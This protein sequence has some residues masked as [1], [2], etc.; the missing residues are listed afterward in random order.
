MDHEHDHEE[1]EDLSERSF[2]V[3]WW[4]KLMLLAITI[5]GIGA[6]LHLVYHPIALYFGLPCP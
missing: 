4:H 5:P 2:L 3:R 6:A 1:Q